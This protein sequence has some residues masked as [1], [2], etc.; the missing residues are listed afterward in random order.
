MWTTDSRSSADSRVILRRGPNPVEHIWSRFYDAKAGR[1]T[2]L[3][4]FGGIPEQPLSLHKYLYAEGD[5]VN[6][7]DPSGQ[8]TLTQIVVAV[9]IGLN[10]YSFVNHATAAYEGWRDDDPA[11]ANENAIL[12]LVDA[13]FLGL[14]FMGPGSGWSRTTAGTMALQLSR[15]GVQASTIWGY[16][17]TLMPAAHDSAF[18]YARSNN[19]KPP[20]KF[21]YYEGPGEWRSGAEPAVGPGRGFQTSRTGKPADWVFWLNGVKFDG[22]RSAGNTL[23]DTK[24]EG[25]EW[26]LQQPWFRTSGRGLDDMVQQA[27]DQLEAAQGTGAGILWEVQGQG[28]ARAIE[29]ELLFRRVPVGSNG[30]NVVAIP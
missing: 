18:I 15:A 10:A 24:G 19:R 5:P 14:P 27:R 16:L 26:I 7:I 20:G 11:K 3:D 17:T 4:P 29:R 23:L 8:Y 6:G 22:Y 13:L 30:I 12:A 9:G 28:S 21:E 25:W 2:S 1:F